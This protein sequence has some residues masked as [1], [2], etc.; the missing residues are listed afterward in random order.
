MPVN[1][2][3]DVQILIGMGVQ[4]AHVPVEVC[5]PPPVASGPNALRT[6]FGWCLV[7]RHPTADTERAGQGA[8]VNTI[9]VNRV[10]DLEQAVEMFWRTQ[11]M[12][13]CASPK[14]FMAPDDKA[15]L[16][17]ME[18]TIRHDGERYEV[19]LPVRESAPPLPDNQEAARRSFLAL[20]RQLRTD[21]VLRRGVVAAVTDTIRS[22]VALSSGCSRDRKRRR[23]ARS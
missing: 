10:Q 6:P 1:S 18:A 17:H 2:A 3:P 5:R 22:C 8:Q 12:P 14:S 15:A 16:E 19:G 13:V 21:D 4:D 23:N 9:Q 11:S 7:G 20:E